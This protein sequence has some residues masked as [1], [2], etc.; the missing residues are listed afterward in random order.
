MVDHMI[1][2]PWL[3]CS[4]MTISSLTWRGSSSRID[5][6]LLH[7]AAAL[8]YTKLIE[9]FI[10][11][12]VDNPSVILEVEV[13]AFSCDRNECTP[14]M[15]SLAKGHRDSAVLLFRWN[16]AA[17]NLC[18]NQGNSPVHVARQKGFTRLVEDIERLQQDLPLLGPE[19]SSVDTALPH[20]H[21]HA[22]QTSCG[23][24]ARRAASHCAPCHAS[25]QNRR[26]Y[27][28]GGHS[29]GFPR[30]TSSCDT[31][32]ELGYS[33]S[34]DDDLDE[35]SGSNPCS[36]GYATS[37]QRNSFANAYDASDV[38]EFM[39]CVSN[40]RMTIAELSCRIIAAMPDRIK[41][42][43]TASLLDEPY[44]N[45]SQGFGLDADTSASSSGASAS[46]SH[47]ACKLQD[48]LRLN[49]TSYRYCDASS[50][51]S[52]PASS[53]LQSPLNNLDPQSS[54]PPTTADL[55][56]F[57]QASGKIMQKEFSSLT[58][59]DQE[60]RELYV[61][62]KTIQK[63]YRMYKGR[64]RQEQEKERQAAVLIQSYYRR[65][66]QYVYYKQ[67]TKAAQVIQNQFRNYCEHKRFKKC[68]QNRFVSLG[69][70]CGPSSSSNGNLVIQNPFYGGESERKSSRDSLTPTTG[71]K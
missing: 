36:S 32:V 68:S 54:P 24:S 43:S 70:G 63:A 44:Q 6:S 60:Q 57:F 13:D 11:W 45:Q 1:S 53:C 49:Y 17:I 21:H 2:S 34:S 62:A 9:R 23:R 16:K 66:K 35:L 7:L 42:S 55:C 19:P 50:T 27:F 38:N 37:S 25:C 58:L 59:S 33:S 28:C 52:S 14:L 47:A 4:S 64:K 69:V 10:T 40:E 3:P 71:L 30:K 39:E 29:A 20:R 15:W 41:A 31:G 67:M 22:P 65:Y 61:A 18:N 12:R 56:E 51:T 5:M 46:L 8:G 48:A 26:I